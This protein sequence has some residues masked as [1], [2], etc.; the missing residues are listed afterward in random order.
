MIGFDWQARWSGACGIRSL[1]HALLCLGI[2]VSEQAASRAATTNGLRTALLGIDEHQMKFAIRTFGVWPRVLCTRSSSRARAVVDR[3]LGRHRPVIASCRGGAHWVVLCGRSAGR[4]MWID[5]ANDDLIGATHWSQLAPSLLDE[6]DAHY[7]IALVPRRRS[8]HRW[9]LVGGFEAAV[10]PALQDGHLCRTWGEHASILIPLA[11]RRALP[12]CLDMAD[13]LRTCE[14][15]LVREARRGSLWSAR[16]LV[17][18]LVTVSR[19]HRFQIARR[20]VESAIITIRSM[21][22]TCA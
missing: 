19:A 9:S 6:N 17:R 7:L 12:G 8:N 5:S 3:W 18:R 4:Y 15:G 2:P 20:D 1:V 14:G 13:V 11:E 10:W 21:V 16:Q 22:R